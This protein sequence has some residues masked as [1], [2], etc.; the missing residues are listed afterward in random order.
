[1]PGESTQPRPKLDARSGYTSEAPP[2]R[3]LAA[4]A[5]HAADFGVLNAAIGLGAPVGSLLAST[6]TWNGRHARCLGVGVVLGAPRSPS[7]AERPR[8]PPR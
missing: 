4:P 7:S 3:A 2:S 1:M 5:H 8:R 6:I